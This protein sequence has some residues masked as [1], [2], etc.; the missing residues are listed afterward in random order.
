MRAT[1]T[2]AIALLPFLVVGCG[3]GASL[4]PNVTVKLS[5]LAGR[6]SDSDGPTG[7]GPDGPKV[8]GFGTFEGQIIYDGVAAAQGLLSVTKDKEVC[9]ATDLPDE[10][11]IV[12]ADGGV[13]NVF[14]YIKK[15]P[16]GKHGDYDTG[17]GKFVFDQKQCA[18]IPH[19]MIVPCNKPL[20]VLNADPIPHNTRNVPKKNTG[21]SL[22][23][24]GNVRD[25]GSTIEYKKAEAEPIPVKCDYHSWMSAYHLPIDHPFA[26]LSGNDGKF[27]IENIPSGV[28]QFNFWHERAGGYIKG[29]RSIKVT[30]N[31]NETTTLDV[32]YTAN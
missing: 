13:A 29:Y 21:T 4:E 17:A 20:E 6:G 15:A 9:A 30:I 14:V 31:A 26:A 25:G 2:A 1:I 18:F 8:E 3:G 28:H 27:R 7:P 24:G 16:K 32:K 10:S 5:A 22:L 11:L 12:G 19:A 23:V